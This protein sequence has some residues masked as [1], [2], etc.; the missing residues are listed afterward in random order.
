MRHSVQ[1]HS[2]IQEQPLHQCSHSNYYHNRCHLHIFVHFMSFQIIFGLLGH[3]MSH[4]MYVPPGPC[5]SVNVTSFL[6][7][8]SDVATV[9]WIA[10]PGALTHTVLAQDGTSHDYISCRTNTTSCQL[11]QL[12]CGKVYNLTVMSEDATCNSTGASHVIM[13]G[14]ETTHS[15][16]KDVLQSLEST[17]T[18][19]KRGFFCL[20]R[21]SMSSHFHE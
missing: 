10:S 17:N 7:C 3:I 9:S 5:D 15:K 14:R 1:H 6:H 11:K 21:S 16:N 20:L 19:I 18:F 4:V 12:Q 13:T 2:S 8:G